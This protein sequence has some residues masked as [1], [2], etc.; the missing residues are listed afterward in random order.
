M[1]TP[2]MLLWPNEPAEQDDV[3][4]E[5]DLILTLISDFVYHIY[6][7]PFFF[8]LLGLGSAK[9]IT[10]LLSAAVVRVHLLCKA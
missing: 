9:S 4:A 3:G 6:T 5:S 2:R 7:L 8:G 1:M 10:L